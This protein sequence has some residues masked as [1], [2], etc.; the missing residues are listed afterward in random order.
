MQPQRTLCLA[1]MDILRAVKRIEGRHVPSKTGPNPTRPRKSVHWRLR[2]RL[3]GL[4]YPP[5]ITLLGTNTGTNIGP[6]ENVFR[7]RAHRGCCQPSSGKRTNDLGRLAPSRSRA[8]GAALQPKNTKNALN[9]STRRSAICA[10]I[11]SLFSI[12]WAVSAANL[13]SSSFRKDCFMTV[14][15]PSSPTASLR[16]LSYVRNLR[17]QYFS[18]FS[19]ITFVEAVPAFVKAMPQ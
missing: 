16:S 10:F 19:D 7:C 8:L 13:G 1:T 14:N 15:K 12:S 11:L 9:E 5:E 4:G 18:F 3:D 6:E 17:V 2:S